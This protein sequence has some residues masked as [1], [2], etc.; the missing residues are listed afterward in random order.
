MLW[1]PPQKKL[2]TTFSRFP[3]FQGA[4]DRDMLSVGRKMSRRNKAKSTSAGAGGI[5]P[6][7]KRGFDSAPRLKGGQSERYEENLAR[8]KRDEGETSR[9]G[10]TDGG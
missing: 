5:A 8:V 4:M 1:R 10:P 6:S 3:K 7:R 9:E 2:N